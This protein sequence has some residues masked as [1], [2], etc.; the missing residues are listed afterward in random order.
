MQWTLD[1]REATRHDLNLKEKGYLLVDEIIEIV[2]S[3]TDFIFHYREVY[4]DY[5]GNIVFARKLEDGND[6]FFVDKMIKKD[7]LMG[8]IKFLLE[9]ES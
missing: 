7:R 9:N 1:P 8:K 3:L 6:L 5:P 2:E 4:D